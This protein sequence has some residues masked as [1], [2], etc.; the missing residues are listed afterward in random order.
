MKKI[1]SIVLSSLLILGATAKA[2]SLVPESTS[3]SEKVQMEGFICVYYGGCIMQAMKYT[4]LFYVMHLLDIRDS[5][6]QMAKAVEDAKFYRSR[7]IYAEPPQNEEGIDGKMLLMIEPGDR[8]TSYQSVDYGTYSTKE[9]VEVKLPA[10]TSVIDPT[11]MGLRGIKINGRPLVSHEL[12]K[13][14]EATTAL[15]Y[16]EVITV[17]AKYKVK[18]ENDHYAVTHPL[19]LNEMLLD[20]MHAN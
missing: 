11:A 12:G 6:K 19:I 9:D 1:L 14:W 20:F 15:V 3:L 17:P 7:V 16:D 10:N 13:A 8:I 2:D 4:G 5:K 18:K